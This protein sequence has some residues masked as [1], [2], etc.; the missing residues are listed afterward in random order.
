MLITRPISRMLKFPALLYK[1]QLVGSD[2]SESCQ[3]PDSVDHIVFHC[4]KYRLY[5]IQSWE[6]AR[7]N[8]AAYSNTFSDFSEFFWADNGFRMDTLIFIFQTK[9]F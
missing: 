3:V 5:R 9:S 6:R 8:I 1:F 7:Y 4:T 2:K